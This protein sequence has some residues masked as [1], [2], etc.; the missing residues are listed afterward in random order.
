[1]LISFSFCP[2]PWLPH[3]Q[4]NQYDL[5]NVDF[6]VLVDQLDSLGLFP[7]LP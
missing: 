1:M 7:P 2:L 5:L 3:L 4:A 6:V